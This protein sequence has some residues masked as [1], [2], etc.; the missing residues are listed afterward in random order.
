MEPSGQPRHSGRKCMQRALLCLLGCA[1]GYPFL[2]FVCLAAMKSS[3]PAWPLNA[4][5]GIECG[6]VVLCGYF[7][8]CGAARIRRERRVA[9]RASGRCARCGYS[10]AEI[11]S[12]RCPECGCGREETVTGNPASPA[13]RRASFLGGLLVIAGIVLGGSVYFVQQLV[14]ASPLRVHALPVV[15]GLLAQLA[16]AGLLAGMGIEWIRFGRLSGN[17]AEDEFQAQE[18]NVT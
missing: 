12:Q 16:S 9:R 11:E 15:V 7:L 13:R 18:K 4:A 10:L 5:I 3:E 14:F 8:A 2:V 1:M 6:L 17:P